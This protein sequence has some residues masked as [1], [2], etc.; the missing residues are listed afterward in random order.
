MRQHAPQQ[1]E[2][3]DLDLP[4][5]DRPSPRKR[6]PRRRRWVAG[7]TGAALLVVGA[8][9]LH[10]PAPP[11]RPDDRDILNGPKY[12]DAV[13]YE[14]RAAQRRANEQ[15]LLMTVHQLVSPWS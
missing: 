10:E 6:P 8:S 9:L 15:P 2:V 12:Q 1:V 5:P 14:R 3:V 11:T 4:V 7:A 13:P